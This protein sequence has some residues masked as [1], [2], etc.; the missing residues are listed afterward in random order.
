M[1]H[2]YLLIAARELSLYCISPHDHTLLLLPVWDC[3]N[4][5]T[6]LLD[7]NLELS[8]IPLSV[9]RVAITLGTCGC[10]KLYANVEELDRVR[11]LEV[12]SSILP[13][14]E[15][16]ARAVHWHLKGELSY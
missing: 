2:G 4:T 3:L 5:R 14:A 16:A 6:L 1:F 10:T 15:L 9:L 12:C 8:A 7:G 13:L 11:P